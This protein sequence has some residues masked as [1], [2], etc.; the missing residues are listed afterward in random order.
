M[1]NTV[2]ISAN[3][4]ADVFELLQRSAREQGITMTELIRRGITREDFLYEEHKKG[5]KLL[6]EDASGRLRELVIR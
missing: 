4:P 3:L 5:S 2:K 6:I 1:A